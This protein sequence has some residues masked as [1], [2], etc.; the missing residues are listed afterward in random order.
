ME[1]IFRNPWLFIPLL[2]WSLFWKGLAL[3]KAARDG[4]KAWFII[5]L[6]INTI[7]ILEILYIFVFSKSIFTRRRNNNSLGPVS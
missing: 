5:L 3:W 1:M 2:I 6:V 7:G 4:S